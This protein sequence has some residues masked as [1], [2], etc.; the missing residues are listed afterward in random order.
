MTLVK[1]FDRQISL[2]FIATILVIMAA[3]YFTFNKVTRDHANHQHQTIV[4]LITLLNSELVRPLQVSY[5][6]ANDYFITNLAQ[7]NV[8]QEEKVAGYLANIKGKYNLLAFLALERHNFMLDSDGKQLTLTEDESEWYRRLKDQSLDYYADIGNSDNPHLYF[9][10]KIKNEVGEFLG[11]AGVAV[12]LDYFAQRFSIYKNKYGVELFV[13]DQNNDITLSS[14]ITMKTHSHHRKDEITNLTEFEWFN[15][16][17][18]KNNNE[19]ISQLV[20]TQD[21][22]FMVSKLPLPELS[23]DMYIVAPPHYLQTSYWR[24]VASK[25][26]ILLLVALS[27]YIAFER[28]LRVFKTNV[29]QNSE[30]DF[31]T[32]LPNRSYINWKIEDI[33]R[34][35]DSV[36]VVVADIDK[37][38]NINDKYG[39]L[40]GDDVLKSVASKLVEALRKV[41]IVSRWGGEE[42]LM[43]LPETSCEQAK[44]IT[45]RIRKTIESATINVSSSSEDFFVTVSFGIA[46]GTLQKES[47]NDIIQ[48]AD[49]A[50]YLAKTNGRNQVVTYDKKHDKASDKNSNKAANKKSDKA[51]QLSA[52]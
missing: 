10:A 50:L 38:K 12:D 6:M 18:A 42:F 44:E 40:V 51:N 32:Q 47:L 25:V 37:F 41:D 49:Q 4:P 35:Y 3:S 52:G 7:Q 17:Q 11:F 20:D 15:A 2:V 23:W 34:D 27:L 1:R 43:I 39:H 31:L 16:Y 8:L 14:D 9:D 19:Q 48:K 24:L 5:Y 22:K 46:Q 21:A 45:E 28:I 30:T 36:S 26:V 33:R 13:A 29:V